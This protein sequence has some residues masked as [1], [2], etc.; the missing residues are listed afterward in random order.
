MIF[1]N[2]FRPLCCNDLGLIA[3]RNYNF[4]PFID[5]SCRREPDFQNKYPSISALCRGSKFAPLVKKNDIILY[6]TIGG[7]FTPYKKGHHLVAIL[8][9]LNVFQSHSLG[10]SWYTNY[11]SSIPSN[12]MVPQ[13]HPFDFDKTAGDFK[14]NKQIKNFLA[15]PHQTQINIGQR[16]LTLWD[17]M[18]L[19]R[20]QRWPCFISTEPIYLE[21]NN[22]K[23]I[24]RNDFNKNFGKIPN[25]QIPQKITQ[26]QLDHLYKLAGL[27]S[28]NLNEQLI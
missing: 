5:S 16:R 7:V 23:N 22:P 4:P 26:T 18:Y 8:K 28:S 12:C 24:S 10:A 17:N 15:R 27:P 14:T 20:S 2:S 19:Q 21:F 13:N 9:V 1:L 6:M 11:S 3:I 25:T